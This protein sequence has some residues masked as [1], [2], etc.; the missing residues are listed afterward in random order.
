M[1]GSSGEADGPLIGRKVNPPANAAI[2]CFAGAEAIT[3][4]RSSLARDDFSSAKKVVSMNTV[5]DEVLESYHRCEASSGLFDS[6][7]DIFFAKSPGIPPKF[8]STDMEQQKQ[9]VM[10][11]VLMALRLRTGDPVARQYVQEIAKSHS[12]RGHNI[13]AELYELWPDALCEAIKMHDPRYTPQL[14]E[15]WRQAMCPTIEV[16]ISAY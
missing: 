11:S 7:Y 2:T 9:I 6:F 4:I 8:A 14:E 15:R 5:C 12:R 16:M 1:K 13:N 10:A 3:A